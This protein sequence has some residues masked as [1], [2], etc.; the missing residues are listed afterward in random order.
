MLKS[1]RIKTVS[2]RK[3]KAARKFGNLDEKKL[4]N[5]TKI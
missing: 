1:Q 5:G 4:K 2:K 3:E